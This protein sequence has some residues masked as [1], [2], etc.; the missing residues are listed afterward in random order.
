MSSPCPG[1]KQRRNSSP[2][3]FDNRRETERLHRCRRVG[4]ERGDACQHSPSYGSICTFVHRIKQEGVTP[5]HSCV[6]SV[7]R[8]QRQEIMSVTPIIG[9]G[10]SS[11]PTCKLCVQLSAAPTSVFA[12][13]PAACVPGWSR[14]RSDLSLRCSRHIGR[15]PSPHPSREGTRCVR[16]PQ[17][18]YRH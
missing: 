12:Y 8:S 9:P 5:W 11:T 15:T 16:H 10:E 17:P 6:N 14:R 1:A 3:H 4:F 18:F 13:A 7:P 2:P